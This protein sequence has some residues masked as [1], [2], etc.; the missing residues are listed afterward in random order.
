MFEITLPISEVQLKFRPFLVREQKI[1]LMA[2]ESKDEK[3]IEMNIQQI[4]NNCNLTD[5]DI[6][7]LPLV[8]IEYYF[9]NLRAKS[10]GEDV[11]SRYKCEN[12]VEDKVCGNLMDVSF[13]ILN[14][15]ITMPEEGSDLIKI[16]DKLGVKMK[17]PSFSVVK[18]IKADEPQIESAFKLLI[19]CI[20]YV[21]DGDN[22]Y[23]ANEVSSEELLQFVESMTK[24]QF[25]KVESFVD[26]LPRLDK[27]VNVTCKKCGFDHRI[28]LQGLQSFFG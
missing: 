25:A 21:Y 2:M 5:V 14:V 9:L 28:E 8:D 6:D 26:K 1:L 11:E 27:I 10:V 23:Y 24:E 19:D 4:L 7:T 16:T 18:K 22:L 12:V 3:E 17:Y 20:D 15:N 13:D